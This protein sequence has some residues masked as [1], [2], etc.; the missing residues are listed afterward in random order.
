MDS[1][2]SKRHSEAKTS[3]TPA[4][5]LARTVEH[6]L[7]N[8]RIR[9]PLAKQLA[10]VTQP[11]MKD[12]AINHLVLLRSDHHYS[13]SNKQL[14]RFHILFPIRMT[15]ASFDKHNVLQQ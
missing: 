5:C 9:Q 7:P 13:S 8:D 15:A 11:T 3:N 12:N 1:R 6:F 10:A 4:K 2:A 14:D